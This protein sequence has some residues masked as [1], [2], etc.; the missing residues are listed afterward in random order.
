MILVFTED[1]QLFKNIS[2]IKAK[3]TLAQSRQMADHSA[4]FRDTGTYYLTY[5]KIG[6][7][8]G[9]EECK[10]FTVLVTVSILLCKKIMVKVLSI[11]QLICAKISMM[12][13]IFKIC[14]N[15]VVKYRTF[16]PCL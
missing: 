14:G 4:K 8:K 9:L 6:L 7:I 16:K 10:N 15:Y 3:L 13:M 12:V 2:D 5:E 11:Y 1:K